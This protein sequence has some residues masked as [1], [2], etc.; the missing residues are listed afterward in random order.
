MTGEPIEV[1]ILAGL[2]VL[3][4]VTAGVVGYLVTVVCADTGRGTTR[5][6]PNRTINIHARLAA[7]EAAVN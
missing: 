2:I 1:L 4:V 3:F 7:L 6:I 5:Y